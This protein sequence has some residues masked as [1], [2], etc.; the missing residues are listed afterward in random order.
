MLFA[1]SD[2]SENKLLPQVTFPLWLNADILPGPVESTV[3]PVD[4][5]KFL[6][7]GSQHPRTVLSVGWTTNYGGNITE[8]EYSR[9]QIGTM[10]RMINENHV[11]QTVTFPVSEFISL[12]N[13]V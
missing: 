4:P 13:N 12:M 7:L 2:L 1:K 5:V 10:L 3:K 9:E 11:S 8:G 6:K